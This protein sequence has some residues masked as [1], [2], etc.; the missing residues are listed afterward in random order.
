MLS[1][2]SATL[3]ELP[4]EDTTQPALKE[5]LSQEAPRPPAQPLTNGGTLGKF[6]NFSV[7]QLP[8]L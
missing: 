2:Y 8:H 6:L 1:R 7:P 4:A 3:G 5:P